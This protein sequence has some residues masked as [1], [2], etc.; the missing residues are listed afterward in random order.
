MSDRDRQCVAC[1]RSKVVYIASVDDVFPGCSG[2]RGAARRAWE[3]G[4]THICSFSECQTS[5]DRGDRH[6]DTVRARRYD[7]RDEQRDDDQGD[8][9][10]DP[11]AELADSADPVDSPEEH[12]GAAGV[13]APWDNLP[14]YV[15][16]TARFLLFTVIQRGTKPNG[17][18]NYAKVPCSPWVTG[19][20]TPT[21][22]GATHP[23]NW[24]DFE[25]AVESYGKW[26]EHMKGTASPVML[27]WA[28][29]PEDDVVGID[30]D[31]CVDPETGAIQ[32]Y[33]KELLAMC[34]SYAEYSVSGTGIH[35]L[36]RGE[37]ASAIANKTE[38]VEIYPGDRGFVMTGDHI[39]PTP[40]EI[41]DAQEA[42]DYCKRE[43][44]TDD[45]DRSRPSSRSTPTPES[46]D[47]EGSDA[48]FYDMAAVDV[49]PAVA[50][51][52]NV[53]HPFHASSTGA[54]FKL[55]SDGQTAICWSGGHAVGSGPG[56]GLGAHHLAAMEMLRA[57][58][59]VPREFAEYVDSDGVDCA[60][61]RHGWVD[62]D[63][64]V[65]ATYVH[66]V[67]KGYC[68]ASP[69]PYRAIR[70][71]AAELDLL[72]GLE[73]DH[74]RSKWSLFRVC[75]RQIARDEAFT[76]DVDA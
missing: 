9:Q 14:D 44:Q 26:H 56:C 4:D 76:I 49:L 32:T 3:R 72:D 43:Y 10:G 74:K 38:D 23:D 67:R 22:G 39:P 45:D 28:F 41:R 60:A 64:L 65:L 16:A 15:L 19:N 37:L 1:G 30:L 75:A 21:D 58:D 57:T 5:V 53:A 29:S 36:V 20:I 25:T 7:G 31:D 12:D 24:T 17:D 8:V 51:D 34:D 2:L 59:A 6:R 54:N 13:P 66:S 18:P 73:G 63:A 55:H 46:A 33:A 48:P 62:D 47:G 27:G 50:V 68:E 40:R 52:E 42:L 70:A 69:P 61:L 35:I 71:K 11:D